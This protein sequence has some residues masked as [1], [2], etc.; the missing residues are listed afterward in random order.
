[1]IAH[2]INLHKETDHFILTPQYIRLWDTSWDPLVNDR[3]I[4]EPLGY[5]K[6]INPEQI[7]ENSHGSIEVTKLNTFKWAGGWFTLRIRE[8]RETR[9]HTTKFY[10]IRTR[11]YLYDGVL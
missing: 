1:M 3:Y 11:R 9:K 2:G 5:Y 4:H 8:T 6:S 7:V 10:W